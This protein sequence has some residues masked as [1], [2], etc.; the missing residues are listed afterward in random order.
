[1]LAHLVIRLAGVVDLD[2][3]DRLRPQ[4][5]RLHRCEVGRA[6]NERADRAD[7]RVL[8]IGPGSHGVELLL[9]HPDAPVRHA[10]ALGPAVAVLH[11]PRESGAPDLLERHR[12]TSASRLAT[13]TPRRSRSRG[14]R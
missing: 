14:P 8:W 10:A 13:G 2:A 4:D 12:L 6:V 5:R 11:E 1:A 7:S 3:R 9:A